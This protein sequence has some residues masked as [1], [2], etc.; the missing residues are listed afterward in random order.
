MDQ[1]HYM[2][3]ALLRPEDRAKAFVVHA[4]NCEL[5]QVLQKSKLA[6]FASLKFKWWIDAVS[7]VCSGDGKAP[8]HPVTLSLEEVASS[9]M[10]KYLL[11]KI[12]HE[13]LRKAEEP[14]KIS[15]T[16]DSLEQHAESTYSSLYY[17]I[18]DAAKV[19]CVRPKG[20]RK[21]TIQNLTGCH[22]Y[23]VNDSECHHAASHMGKAV[24]LARL[25]MSIPQ[26]VVNQK[27]FLPSDV[28][29]ENKLVSIC[30]L[31]ICDST[32]F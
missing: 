7:K 10:A 32:R 2:C 30:F 5:E 31:D 28:C 17:L 20:R 24:G 18:L 21:W 16:I 6:Q 15:R 12:V 8:H 1:A 14:L 26:D 25:L 23:Q 27:I 19:S 11:S 13:K 22:Y 9:R 29:L 4:F 3:T